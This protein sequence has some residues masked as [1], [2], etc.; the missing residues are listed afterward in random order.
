MLDSARLLF[1]LHHVSQIVQAISGCLDARKIAQH[2]TDALVEQFDCVFARL[3]LMEADRTALRLVASSG[4]HTHLDGSFARV[5]VGAYKVGKIAQNRVPFLS[6]HL[7]EEPWVKDR[8]WAISNHIQGFAGYP[9]IANDR[10]IGVLATFSNQA[11]APEFLEV[12][13]VLCLTTTIALDAATRVAQTQDISAQRA[14]SAGLPLSDQMAAVLRSTCLT[15]VGT[16]H[17]LPA[18]LHYTLLKAV[19]QLNQYRCNYCRLSYQETNMALEAIIAVPPDAFEEAEAWVRSQF[20]DLRLLTAW[21]EGQLDLRLV[22]D[23][24]AI[25]FFLEI[26]YPASQMADPSPGSKKLSERE[27]EVMTLLAQGLRDR[28]IAQKLYI[29]ESTVKFHI[30]NS[31]TKLNAR[32]RYQGVY[33]AAIQGCI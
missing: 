33:Q 32:N 24:K 18:T 27:W 31:L 30:N 1:D 10:V 16:E 26:P 4:L 6:N 21:L 13:Q 5:P 15:L 8:D 7:A 2:I 28:D 12:L 20:N 22:R 25:Q 14:S 3:W 17:P 9:L 29:S 23:R 19:E 11:M